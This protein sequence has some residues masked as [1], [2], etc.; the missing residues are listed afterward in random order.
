[1]QRST[2]DDADVFYRAARDPLEV[3]EEGIEMS[4]APVTFSEVDKK[5]KR[6]V[7]KLDGDGGEGLGA[8]PLRPFPP[9]YF[10]RPA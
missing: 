1:V 10:A 4:S 2:T 3:D 6:V 8:K 5:G 9:K 7:R